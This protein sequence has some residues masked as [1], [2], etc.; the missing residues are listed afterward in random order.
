LRLSAGEGAF[1]PRLDGLAIWA[2][3]SAHG[4]QSIP[5]GFFR[6]AQPFSNW[7][8]F[9]LTFFLILL[10]SLLWET[11]L[12]VPYGWWGYRPPAMIGIDVGA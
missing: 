7:R 9:G 12:G 3:A 4:Q 10:V 8:A 1:I 11:T 5:S 2:V 6:T